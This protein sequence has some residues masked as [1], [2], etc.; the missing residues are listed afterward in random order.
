MMKLHRKNRAH[1]NAIKGD[2]TENV[3]TSKII[4][5]NNPASRPALIALGEYFIVL[6]RFVGV[7]TK[8]QRKY[9]FTV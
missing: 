4:T 7:H 8:Q 2:I 1:T 5:E 9:V 6:S 3:N